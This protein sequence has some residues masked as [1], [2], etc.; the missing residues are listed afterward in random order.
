MKKKTGMVVT[1]ITCL[2]LVISS[3]TLLPA[4]NNN[5]EEKNFSFR[6][7]FENNFFMKEHNKMTLSQKSNSRNNIWIKSDE[8]ILSFNDNSEYLNISETVS[9]YVKSIYER[10]K[11]KSENILKY[12]VSSFYHLLI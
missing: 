1:I 11:R 4:H 6:P 7:V 10:Q 9:L 12:A 8:N 3:L 5:A 2:C